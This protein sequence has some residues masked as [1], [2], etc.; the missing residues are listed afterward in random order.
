MT[1]LQ[2][3]ERSDLAVAIGAGRAHEHGVAVPV[4]LVLEGGGQFGKEGFADLGGDEAHGLRLAGGETLGE[5]VRAVVELL[6]RCIDARRGGWRQ[7]DAVIEIAR[8]RCRRDPGI[9]RHIMDRRHC[10]P[11]RTSK[12]GREKRF[13][14]AVS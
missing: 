13:S 14:K 11:T 5:E 10:T 2:A 12:L 4:G 3:L 7:L 1:I 6:D 8:H 9:L